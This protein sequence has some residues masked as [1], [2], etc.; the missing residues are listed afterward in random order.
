M[1]RHKIRSKRNGIANEQRMKNWS[2]S[3]FGEK[4]K[5]VGNSSPS[6]PNRE[7]II[8][9]LRVYW[10]RCRREKKKLRSKRKDGALRGGM[11][12]DVL[13]CTIQLQT[14]KEIGKFKRKHSEYE[15]GWPSPCA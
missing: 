14:G 13:L 11:K 4:D 2:E 5:T 10:D 6:L 15:E 3:T 8:G 9:H 1:H 12:R 7:R